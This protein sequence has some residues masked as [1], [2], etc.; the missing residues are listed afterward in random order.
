MLRATCSHIGAPVLIGARG[1]A[2]ARCD[3][4][5]V[6]DGLAVEFTTV[7]LPPDCKSA[8]AFNRACRAGRVAGARKSGRVW[9]CTR[10]AW[11]VRAKASRPPGLPS[12]VK[13]CAD[14]VGVSTGLLAELG[15]RVAT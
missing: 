2:C 13:A 8:D 3:A 15:A 10:E 11:A 5:I 7:H 4:P 1:L 14:V 6:S 9:I 12:Q